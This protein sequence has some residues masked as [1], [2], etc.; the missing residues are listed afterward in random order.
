MTIIHQHLAVVVSISQLFHCI[1][2]KQKKI[3]GS[4]RGSYFSMTRWLIGVALSP[5][6]SAYVIGALSATAALSPCLSPH[7]SP[8]VSPRLSPHL[9]ACV[10]SG[11]R[12]VCH[13][14]LVSLLVSPL[15]SLRVSSLVS[16]LVCLCGQWSTLCLPLLSCTC[17]PTSLPVCTPSPTIDSQTSPNERFQLARRDPQSSVAWSG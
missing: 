7:F 10:V 5:R 3:A 16:P 17:L 11:R 9:S 8:Y 2:S 1:S 13:C 15:L 12:F 6:L 4:Y 14:C